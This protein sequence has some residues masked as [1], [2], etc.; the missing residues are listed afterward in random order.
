[1]Q[2]LK[3]R[4]NLSATIFVPYDCNNN[5][6][7]C[8]SKQD[9]KDTSNFSLM[10]IAATVR[11]LNSN[12]LIQSYVITGGEPLANVGALDYLLAWCDKPVYINTTLPINKLEASIEFINTTDII[13]GVNISRHINSD[14]NC[15]ATVKDIDRIYKPI[16]INSVLPYGIE[17]DTENYY[18]TI[19]SFINKY[20]KKKRDVNFRADYRYIT[21][22]TLKSPDSVSTNFAQ[23]FDYFMT[24]SCLVC[25][26]EHYS[27]NDEFIVSYHRGLEHSCITFD[28]KCY[29]NDV[30]IKQDGNIYKDWNC[31]SDKEFKEWILK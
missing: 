15:V 27:V 6:P 18:T 25:N 11:K 26:S 20:G 21:Q 8:T 7:F 28:S 23:W 1:M 13:K 19:H 5:C 31:I 3:G 10:N 16:R 24:E 12:P 9:Y 4:T 22:D 17:K 29:V 30:I 14:F 2:Y